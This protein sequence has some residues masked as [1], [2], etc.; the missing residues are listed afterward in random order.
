MVVLIEYL[1]YG[2]NRRPAV[3]L[4]RVPRYLRNN[5]TDATLSAPGVWISVRDHPE[6]GAYCSRPP[7]NSA[8]RFHAMPIGRKSRCW[9]YGAMTVR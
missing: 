8:S 3:L 5:L 2:L 1:R 6:Q 4:G 9:Q 7:A